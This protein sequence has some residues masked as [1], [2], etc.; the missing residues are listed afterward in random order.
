MRQTLRNKQ[1]CG[2]TMR[3]IA[4][5]FRHD[6]NY[7]RGVLRGITEYAVGRPNWTLTPV[8][9]DRAGLRSLRASRPSGVIAHAF[10]RAIDD[11]AGSCGCPAINVAGVLNES[12]MSRVCIDDRR[13]GAEAAAHLLSL[14]LRSLAFL[15][16]PTHRYSKLREAGFARMCQMAGVGIDRYMVSGSTPLGPSGVLDGLDAKLGPFLRSLSRPVGVFACND[17]WGF[18]LTEVCRQQG[19]RVPEDVAIV[20]VDN[21]DLLCLA[22][23]PQL[24][25]VIVP[26][27]RIGFEAARQLDRW[28][29]TG[30][31]PR[32]EQLLHPLGV[33]TRGSTSV[34]ATGDALVKVAIGQ[35]RR[36]LRGD[37]KQLCSTLSVTRRSLERR[38]VQAMGRSP[39]EVI[40]RLRID[41]SCEL[42][43]MTD[44]AVS[45]VAIESGFRD[46]KHLASVFS[47]VLGQSPTAYR[48]A[49]TR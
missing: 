12:S 8:N 17:L 24:S 13:V 36:D 19:L 32:P 48:A 39:F 9:P 4:L 16:H 5:L 45:K 2:L 10:D 46:S 14:G 38:F 33:A 30:K 43:R 34:L 29:R 20:S 18:R 15:G 25:S 7:C 40:T 49:A 3:T 31:A 41:K 11:A 35:M 37:V 47:R 26:S 42:L 44:K 6:L 27:H 22:A 23:R 21:D 28:I 1:Q